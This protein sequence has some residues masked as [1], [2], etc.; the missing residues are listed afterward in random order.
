MDTKIYDKKKLRKASLT[1]VIIF[2]VML[3]FTILSGGVASSWGNIQIKRVTFMGDGGTQQSGLM[4]VPDGVNAEN[5]APAII[6]FHGRNCS[7]YSMINW[8]IEEAR[9][10]YVVFNPDMTGTLETENTISNTLENIT[11]SAYEYMSSLR[12]VT[13]ISVTGHS[14]GNRYLLVLLQDPQIQAELNSVVGVGGFDWYYFMSAYDLQ[15][16][17]ETNYCIIEGTKDLYNIQYMNTWDNVH[18]LLYELAEQGKDLEFGKL[19]GDPN[20]GTAF[21]YVELPVTHQQQMYNKEVIGEMLDFI[22]LSSPAPNPV[23]TDDM[24]FRS[25]QFFSAVCSVLFIC[26]VG[27]LAYTLSC[28]PVCYKTM[29]VP[30]EPS[31][32][33]SWKKWIGDVA[34]AYIIPIALFVPVSMW[35]AKQPTNIFASE[36]VNQIFFWL[37]AVAL[38]SAAILGY[39]SMKKKKI[40]K[41][42]ALDFGTGTVEEKIL[43]W[44]R[45]GTSLGLTLITV[46]TA[47]GWIEFVIKTFGVNY[48]FYCLLAQINRITPER[49]KY[50]IPYLIVCI[51]IVLVI[52]INIATSRRMK[53]T[54]NETLDMIRDIIVNVLLSAGPLSLLMV[55][56]FIGI[57]IIGNGSTP[58]STV[59]WG[60]L[61]FGWMFPLM[62]TS[63]AALSTFLYRKTGHIWLGVFVSSFT[64]IFITVLNCCVSTIVI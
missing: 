23:D 12:M 54:G 16:P 22:E 32:G 45:I 31:Q 50:I 9:R 36:W 51:L 33:K 7:S 29:T 13:D 62:M 24:V 8:A 3:I 18:A 47:F 37:A 5:P 19:Y 2:V 63:S 61:S 59:Y 15:F 28:L 56:Q 20:E 34:T 60:S 48:Q 40:Q 38:V 17:T 35:A 41:L 44:K 26:F 49:L 25:F 52:N 55:I 46:A 14:M 27:A 39:R 1:L 42:T 30:L 11:Y 10:G 21:K 64:L 53:T 6:N 58:L 43:D 57:R 4:F